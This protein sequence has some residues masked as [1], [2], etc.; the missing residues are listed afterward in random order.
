MSPSSNPK[1]AHLKNERPCV[2]KYG[3]LVEALRHAAT[4][5]PERLYINMLDTKNEEHRVT[6]TEMLAEA[7]RWARFFVSR[8]I[9][10]GATIALLLPTSQEVLGAFY[11]AQMAGGTPVP[12]PYPLALGN[13]DAYV[14]GFEHIVAS[15][16][17]TLL[18]TTEQYKEAGLV[19]LRGIDKN[20]DSVVIAAEIED[21][22]ECHFPDISP[23]DLALVQYTSG[24]VG[25][26][27]GVELSHGNILANVLGL[28][29]ALSLSRDD[30]ALNWVPLVQDMGLVGGLF[31]SLYWRCPLH[32]MP[33]QSFLMHPHR[34]LKNIADY[35]VTLSVAPNFAYQLCVRRVRDKHLDG[36]DL[37]R[38]RLAL[39][40]AET[41]YPQSVQAFCDKLAGTK[42]FPS[43]MLPTYGLAEN[44]LATAIP[45]LDNTYTTARHPEDAS[46]EVVSVGGPLAGQELA[47]LDEQ[48]KV[49]SEGELGEIAVRG[50]CKMRGYRNNQSATDRAIRNDWL[51][52]GDI[53]FITG[54]RLF[55]T[56]RKK[57]MI[58][59]MGRNYYPDDIEQIIGSCESV[60]CGPVVAFA[61]NNSD[62]GTEDLVIVAEVAVTDE[63]EIKRTTT[64]L[65]T[66]LLDLLGIRADTIQLVAPGTLA[67]GVGQSARR[68]QIRE[69]TQSGEK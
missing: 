11:G 54:G 20:E 10:R 30:V 13:A 59:K 1:A 68:A 37:S 35:G 6:F 58:I 47:I 3:T 38:W 66:H 33:P 48:G 43:T 67:T 64:A 65:N 39:N 61:L 14:L 52:T 40:G 32:V 27:T 42:F 5:D 4:E 17:P 9:E 49:V 8:G 56:D 55:I 57:E 22:P 44:T 16:N 21:A 12:L 26:P 29:Q 23:T 41:V 63:E 28:G 34:W 18:I 50:P 24:P 45:S 46:R 25:V 62:S 69:R 53:G 51:H 19:L 31:T 2:P 36:L 60:D 15:A 7:E